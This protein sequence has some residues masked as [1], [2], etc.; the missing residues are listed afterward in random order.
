MG[1]NT[2]N[3]YYCMQ[4]WVWRGEKKAVWVGFYFLLMEKIKTKWTNKDS[5]SSVHQVTVSVTLGTLEVTL[6]LTHPGTNLNHHRLCESVFFRGTKPSRY[7]EFWDWAMLM[8]LEWWF[9]EPQPVPGNVHS[10]KCSWQCWQPFIVK[11]AVMRY[12]PGF[13]RL[14]PHPLLKYFM[15]RQ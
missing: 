13:E 9:W 15:F 4:G 1:F 5:G 2:Q 6:Q 11:A 14:V 3:Q 8:S 10:V 12:S 7:L